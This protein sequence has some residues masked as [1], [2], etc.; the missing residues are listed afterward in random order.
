MLCS[1]RSQSLLSFYSPSSVRERLAPPRARVLSRQMSTG[2]ALSTRLC[3]FK[4]AIPSL[5][6]STLVAHI[7]PPINWCS[8]LTLR[9][10]RQFV[11]C[12]SN[13]KL[14]HCFVV[15]KERRSPVA[16][17]ARTHRVCS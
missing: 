17:R 6:P 1:D 11:V 12:R 10:R 9:G 15:L 8:E 4:V 16:R 7:K 2:T 5:S 14:F 13:L 3:S